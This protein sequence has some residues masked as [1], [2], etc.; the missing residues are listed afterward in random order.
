LKIALVLA[1]APQYSETFFIA[2]IKGL[3]AHGYTVTLYVGQ[4]RANFDLCDVVVA[5]KVYKSFFK[6]FLASVM[7]YF[8]LL[9]HLK[10]VRKFIQLERASKRAWSQVLKRLYLN[11]HLLKSHTDWVHF[12]FATL[13]LQREH[14]A[15]AIGAKLAVSFRGFDIDVYPLKH[16]K[17]YDYLWT[18][19]D[20]VHTI[21]DYLATKGQRL[22]LPT[23]VAVT[24]ITP[25]IAGHQFAFNPTSSSP[26]QLLTVARLHWIKGLIETLE[27]LALIKAKGIIFNY[28]IVGDGPNKEALLFAIHQLGLSDVVEVVGAVSADAVATYM[29]AAQIY[30]QYSHSEGFCNA[31]LEAQASGCLCIVSDGGGLPENIIHGQTGWV[32][33]KRQPQLLANCIEKVM[34][35]EPSEKKA[36][37]LR[38]RERVVK[39]FNLEAQQQAFVEFYKV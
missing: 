4:T 1:R 2:K 18:H 36:L 14:V 17:C 21:S 38:A 30:I 13:A 11:S 3:Q 35:L 23:H 32:I 26:V 20:R 12:G 28:R 6:Q 31:V 16:P 10:A 33:P 27:A 29:S 37:Q 25:A 5:P 22:G 9:F 15:K 8:S 39:T 19:V 7:V 24:K 34:H